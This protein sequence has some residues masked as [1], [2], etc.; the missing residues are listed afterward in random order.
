MLNWKIVARELA[1]SGSEHNP[2][3]VN[4]QLIRFLFETLTGND[5]LVR[6]MVSES[7]EFITANTVEELA[8]KMNEL[9]GE[10][11]IDAARLKARVEEYDAVL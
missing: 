5:R 4:H 8:G 11:R 3:I 1:I 9:S 10:K 2:R 7:T 6:Q